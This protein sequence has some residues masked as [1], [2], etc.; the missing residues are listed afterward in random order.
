MEYQKTTPGGISEG[1]SDGIPND[2]LGWIRRGTFLGILF[3]IL[4]EIFRKI[5]KVIL[6]AK[7]GGIQVGI[8]DIIAKNI[9]SEVSI[10]TTG[11]IPRGNSG[12]MCGE[13][14]GGNFEEY[15]T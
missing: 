8:S 12:G 1:I 13:I 14:L 5:L 9:P 6:F 11:K 10:I 15:N 2:I 4:E 3:E 7:L